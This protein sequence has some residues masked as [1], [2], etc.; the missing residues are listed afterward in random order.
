MISSKALRS[1]SPRSRGFR[2][3]QPGNAVSAASS[4]SCRLRRWRSRPWRSPRQSPDSRP[5]RSR[6]RRHRAIPRR[7]RAASEGSGSVACFMAFAFQFIA[8]PIFS[9]IRSGVERAKSSRLPAARRENVRDAHGLGAC[10]GACGYPSD[11]FPVGFRKALARRMQSF[12][13]KQGMTERV[14]AATCGRSGHADLARCLP[15]RDLSLLENVC[16]IL[17]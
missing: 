14:N 2:A 10:A 9:T 4:A 6:R 15:A 8:R 12:A 3:A 16:R 17:C 13:P 5:R 11:D 7:G 1:I